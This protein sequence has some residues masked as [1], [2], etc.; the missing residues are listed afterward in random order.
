MGHLDADGDANALANGYTMIRAFLLVFLALVLWLWAMLTS[1]AHAAVLQDGPDDAMTCGTWTYYAPDVMQRVRG[2]RG[3]GACEDCAGMAAT[4]D[5]RHIGQRIEVWFD[6]AWRGV[7]QVVDVGDGR[8]RAGLVGEV[9][10]ETAR[11]WRRGGPW[12]GCYRVVT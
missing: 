3:L 11:L 5:Q 9:D 6:G 1:S 12:W 10:Y 4:V 2:V 8:N 7:F